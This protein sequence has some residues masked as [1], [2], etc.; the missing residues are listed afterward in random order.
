LATL[1]LETK[2]LLISVVSKN[3]QI[4]HPVYVE[5]SVLRQVWEMIL[6]F[7]LVGFGIAI[8]VIFE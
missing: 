5:K 1:E 8:G 4:G 2:R 7:L 3:K 6:P